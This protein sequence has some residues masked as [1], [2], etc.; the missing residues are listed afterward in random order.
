MVMAY[1]QVSRNTNGLELRPRTDG[2][3]GG[4]WDEQRI[5]AIETEQADH[6]ARI[7]ALETKT[8]P[9][10]VD[11]CFT[12]TYNADHMNQTP[13]PL[14]VDRQ[15][16]TFIS[17]TGPLLGDVA[18]FINSAIS[19]AN[20]SGANLTFT[21]GEGYSYSVV[22]SAGYQWHIADSM[23]F[24]DWSIGELLNNAGDYDQY[25]AFDFDLTLTPVFDNFNV[26]VTSTTVPGS[27]YTKPVAS[28]DYKTKQ[29]TSMSVNVVMT[30][31]GTDPAMVAI[32]SSF[33]QVGRRAS[34]L[35]GSMY[36]DGTW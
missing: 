21:R 27:G 4:D 24:G 18:A 32:A 20:V 3:G 19:G 9:V 12:V 26:V 10:D 2:V 7:T 15:I 35:V 31:H 14:E 11:V 16:Q 13:L 8:A 28:N 5:V 29:I 30:Y 17:E 23:T 6:E 36:C 1:M 22:D 34:V 33:A 25:A